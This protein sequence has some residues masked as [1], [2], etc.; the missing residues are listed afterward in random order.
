MNTVGRDELRTLLDAGRDVLLV[1]ALSTAAYE[2]EHL[3]GAVNVPG[4]LTAELA[5]RLAPDRAA[6]I[7]VYCCGPGCGRSKVTAAAFTRLGYLD[8]RVYPGGKVDWAD[9]GLPFE[10]TRADPAPTAA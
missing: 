7:V 6:P 9:A 5:A 1:E 8:V 3:P 10:G 2:A 4:D